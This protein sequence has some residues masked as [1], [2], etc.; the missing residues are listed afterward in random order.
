M[1]VNEIALADKEIAGWGTEIAR[2]RAKIVDPPRP[3]LDTMVLSPR[4]A[5]PPGPA[6]LPGA[7]LPGAAP[8]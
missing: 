7:A 4:V 3:F 2:V 8:S 1:R 5:A 6:D